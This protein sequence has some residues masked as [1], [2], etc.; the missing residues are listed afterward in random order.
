MFCTNCGSNITDDEVFCTNCGQ[1]VQAGE[2]VN[3]APVMAAPVQP[4]APA[5]E[6][7]VFCTNCGSRITEDE[8][9]CTNCGQAVQTGEDANAVPVMAAPVQSSA[10]VQESYAFCTNCGEKIEEDT[11]FCTKC[12][13]KV[14][15]DSFEQQRILQPISIPKRKKV[16]LAVILSAAGVAVVL[17]IIIIAVSVNNQPYYPRYSSGT[18]T[19]SPPPSTS[20][21]PS[22]GTA[23]APAPSAPPSAPSASAPN[24]TAE[25][26][27][28]LLGTWKYVGIDMEHEDLRFLSL[29]LFWLEGIDIN[30]TAWLIDLALKLGDYSITL[31]DNQITQKCLGFSYTSSYSIANNKITIKLDDT[32][33]LRDLEMRLNGNRLDLVCLLFERL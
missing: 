16:P 22:N 10:P 14:G 21:P 2:N 5:P 18:G 29:L 25:P 15:T 33:S 26:V 27:Y 9:F 24:R 4:P 17:V 3:A 8:V 23:T 19:V 6:E 28:A 30:Q 12:G 13:A 1:A 20:A 11:L 32:L 31:T 7:H